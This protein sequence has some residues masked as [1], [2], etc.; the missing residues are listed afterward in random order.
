MV[1]GFATGCISRG[2]G[3]LKLRSGELRNPSRNRSLVRSMMNVP[4][5]IR[6]AKR[7]IRKAEELAEAE[8]DHAWRHPWCGLGPGD[9]RRW[10]EKAKGLVDR[11]E[12]LAGIAK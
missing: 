6:M 9:A 11:A 5:L 2:T 4:Q 7:A 3:T 10:F 1:S 8:H 12:A